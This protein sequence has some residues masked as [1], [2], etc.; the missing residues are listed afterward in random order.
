MNEILKKIDEEIHMRNEI[1]RNS[2]GMELDTRATIS[3]FQIA[4]QIILTSQSDVPDINVAKIE[5]DDCGG[6]QHEDKQGYEYPCIECQRAYTDEY[7]KNET[8]EGE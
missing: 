2:H 3:G 8:V 6:C 1:I 7:K 4:K 5:H